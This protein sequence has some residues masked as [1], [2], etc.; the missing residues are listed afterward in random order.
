[1]KN[2]LKLFTDVI[3][4]ALALFAAAGCDG[5]MEN[6]VELVNITLVSPYPFCGIG[7]TLRLTANPTPGNLPL[8][9]IV[10]ASS[11]PAVATVDGTGLFT[12][13]SEGEVT[14]TVRSEDRKHE[15]SVTLNVYESVSHNLEITTLGAELVGDNVVLHGRI[16]RDEPLPM[17]DFTKESEWVVSGDGW[18]R[19]YL[20]EG[21]V[22]MRT[23]GTLHAA[24]NVF[25]EEGGRDSF[26]FVHP[27]GTVIGSSEAEGTPAKTGVDQQGSFKHDSPGIFISQRGFYDIYLNPET[28]V[29]KLKKSELPVGFN[30]IYEGY[31][32]GEW[33]PVSLYDSEEFSYVYP[34]TVPGKLNYMAFT[35]LADGSEYTG[36]VDY[37]SI[38][39]NVSDIYPPAGEGVKDMVYSYG[40]KL[41]GDYWVRLSV[42]G[43][44]AYTVGFD[45]EL[46]ENWISAIAF[47]DGKYYYLP[48]T[49]DSGAG[50]G[51]DGKATFY[52]WIWNTR[53]PGAHAAL[54]NVSESSPVDIFLKDIKG[55]VFKLHFTELGYGGMNDFLYNAE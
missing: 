38:T 7:D 24:S 4:G 29:Y 45:P 15:S 17:K 55:G 6:E 34:K 30:I 44:N 10:W 8:P 25:L 46:R 22:H 43:Y 3:A 31:D 28:G 13:V 11:N 49:S 47:A 42:Q 32:T 51:H 18:S 2:L 50:S 5:L 54:S 35:R 1:M 12:G 53:A 37:K 39:V 33:T 40:V 19:G 16:T 27:D 36:M 14:V 21:G 48:M 23:D 20:P 26:A 41:W 52:Y 9:P